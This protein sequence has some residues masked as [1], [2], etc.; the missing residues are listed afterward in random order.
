MYI[1]DVQD[2]IKIIDVGHDMILIIE[3]VTGIIQEVIKGMEGIIIVIT[4]EVAIG[5]KIMI[6]IRVGH[7]KDRIEMEETV[8]A[9]V[10]VD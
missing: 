10:I 4:E 3:V 7:M 2:I 6:E 8:E 9:Q 1:E 5:I